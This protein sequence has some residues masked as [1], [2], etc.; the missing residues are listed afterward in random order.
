MPHFAVKRGKV[1]FYFIGSYKR[2]RKLWSYSWFEVFGTH[3]VVFHLL[4]V[5]RC[6]PVL[7]NTLLFS[8]ALDTICSSGSHLLPCLLLLVVL[9]ENLKE[10]LA[11]LPCLKVCRLMKNFLSPTAPTAM[12]VNENIKSPRPIKS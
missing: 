8:V 11:A 2:Q 4:S 12:V 10:P 9:E 1:N 5:Q 3:L 6:H 7:L